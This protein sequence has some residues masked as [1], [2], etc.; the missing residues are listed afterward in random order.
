MMDTKKYISREMNQQNLI[1]NKSK[2]K[3][4]KLKQSNKLLVDKNE[5]YERYADELT[6]QAHVKRGV[7]FKNKPSS[8]NTKSLQN[9]SPRSENGEKEVK[10]VS[11]MNVRVTYDKDQAKYEKYAGEA[12]I[13]EN[14]NKLLDLIQTCNTENAVFKAEL[15]QF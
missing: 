14:R 9:T 4:E 7:K 8:V 2:Y 12:K 5:I 13:V 1:I 6:G 11:N 3:L 10:K 15:D